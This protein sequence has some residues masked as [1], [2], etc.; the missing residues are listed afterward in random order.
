MTAYYNENDPYAAEWLRNLMRAG[1]I[2]PGFVDDRSILEVEAADL[3]PFDQCHFFA[4]IGVWSHA[5]RSAGWPDAR[6]V[7]TGSPPCQPFSN[8]GKARGHQDKRHLWPTWRRLLAECRPAV[9]LG[10]QVASTDGLAWLDVVLADMENDSYAVA[11]ANLCAAGLGAPH[12]RQR[13]YFVALADARRLGGEPERFDLGSA[14]GAAAAEEREQ[15]VR[16]DDRAG[17]A[18]DDMADAE[19]Q[20]RTGN[21]RPAAGED[22]RGT[23][24]RG[25]ACLFCGYRFD[26]ERLGLYGCANC[27]GEGG[28]GDASGTRLPVRERP[29]LRRKVRPEARRTAGESGRAFW[30]DADWLPCRDGKAR[31]VEP[32]TFPLADGATARV[33]RLRAYGNA[34][35]A[36]VA[37]AFIRAVMS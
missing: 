37:A 8:A 32:G 16:D 20:R 31:P 18:A 13:L 29:K 1:H 23:D 22:S 36:P 3:R 28:V 6:P 7:W 15:R 12:I 34:L 4:G 11:A 27:L 17:G 25:E 10:E 9:V 26:R 24:E 14:A 30:A 5:L 21:R 35:C 2:A 33:G 19:G